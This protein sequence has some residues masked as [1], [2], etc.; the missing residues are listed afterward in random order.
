MLALALAAGRAPAQYGAILS[1]TGAVNRSFGGVATATPLSAA[2]AL[3]WN[4]AT[5][6]G[7]DRSQLEGAAETIFPHT[8]VTSSLPAGSFG[9]LGPPVGLVGR[10]RSDA[11]LCAIPTLAVAYLPEDSPWSYGLGLFA[12][13][14]FGVDYPGSATNP[15]LTPMPP[16]GVGFGPI[17]S[18]FQ[19]LQIAPAVA[20]K[21]TDNFAVAAG[22]TLDIASL[23][24]APGLFA[25][26]NDANGDGFFTYPDASH[27]RVAWGAGFTVGAFYQEQ[28]WAVGASFRSPQWFNSFR[29]N[30][31]DELGRPRE[32]AFRLDLPMIVSVGAS[33]T[34]VESWVFGVDVRYIDY[35]STKGLGE[36]GVAPNGAVRGVG[37]E[38]IWAVALGAQYQ[39]SDEVKLRA[40]YSWNDN[41]IPD[42]VSAL[43]TVAPVILEHVLYTGASW[44][45]TPDFT[46]SVAYL[47]GFRNAITGPV[48][49]AAGP[50]PGTSVRNSA[51][52]DV[53]VIGATV[54]FGG[55]G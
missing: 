20:L 32:L 40:G 46:L 4:P 37:W 29:F 19:C 38:S 11:N 54:K 25:A 8:S 48:L 10:S 44:D 6:P 18:D 41:P 12:L 28:T 43:N 52:A 27:G 24:V 14:G 26:P 13:A 17:Y 47:H 50:V 2:G 49:T 35:S 23:R 22:P 3:Y 9:P 31:T 42:R 34:G 51:A 39:L 15:L 45:V 55:P 30:S 21:L 16:N 33:Y 36:S 7:L 5:M 53:L 1:G